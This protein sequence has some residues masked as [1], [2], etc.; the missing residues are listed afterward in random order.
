MKN[1]GTKGVA[2]V[3]A[4]SPTEGKI[5]EKLSFEIHC[6][7]PENLEEAKLHAQ[8]TADAINVRQQIPFS[9]VELHERYLEAVEVLEWTNTK[10]AL[11]E[12]DKDVLVAYPSLLGE[13]YMVANLDGSAW[14]DFEGRAINI[15]LFHINKWRKI[16]SNQ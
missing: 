10:D 2:R 3:F 7:S 5:G 9:I 4:G 14:Y 11:P 16:Q 15:N 12:T 13:T 6:D 1:E 8:T